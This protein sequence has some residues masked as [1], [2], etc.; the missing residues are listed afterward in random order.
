ML[1]YSQNGASWNKLLVATDN[2][3][4]ASVQAYLG[5]NDPSTILAVAA[6]GTNSVSVEFSEYIIP[7]IS[8]TS[9]VNGGTYLVGLSQGLPVTVGPEAATGASIVRGLL[10]QFGQH[11]YAIRDLN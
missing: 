7:T 4:L 10:Y 6:S 9:P 3:G 1:G 8:I 11:Q 2:N 5:T